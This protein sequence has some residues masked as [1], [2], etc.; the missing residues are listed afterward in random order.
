MKSNTQKIILASILLIFIVCALTAGYFINKTLVYNNHI[1]DCPGPFSESHF[2]GIKVFPLMLPYKVA[3]KLKD[4]SSK[5]GKRVE[6]VDTDF[7]KGTREMLG[8]PRFA[9]AQK[10]IG[11]S[12]LE[13]EVPEVVSWY[14][15]LPSIVSHEIGDTVKVGPSNEQ[16]SL[17]LI[18][19]EQEGDYIDWHFDTNNY[20]GRFFTLLVPV[21]Y[22]DTCGSY[23][24]KD[25]N[26]NEKAID[27]TSQEAIL[28]EGEKVFHKSNKICKDERRV[29]LSC[30]FV[31]SDTMSPLKQFI[32]KIKN[33]FI[34]GM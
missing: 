11:Y 22:E 13:K 9:K 19:Y 16:N 34:F 27:V 21:S 2:C 20:D 30:V 4:I 6:M 23:V 12:A 14:K 25:G 5:L 28:F 26:G 32:Q 24:Y 10:A 8:V 17:S 18:V 31:T 33:L 7:A 15:T 3:N 29:I 1:K